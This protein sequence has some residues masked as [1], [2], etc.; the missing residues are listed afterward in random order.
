MRRS[1]GCTAT[2]CLAAAIT[3]TFHAPVTLAR[4]SSVPAA[5]GATWS[6]PTQVISPV[7]VASWIA[8]RTGTG[9][10]RLQVLVLWRG[11]PGWFL[12]PGGVSGGGSGGRYEA[13]LRYGDVQLTLGYDSARR[14]ATVH[15]KIIEMAED[16]VVFVDDVGAPTGPRVTGMTRVE[17][18]MPGSAGQIGL[19]LRQS[20]AIMSFL[21][22]EVTSPDV[23]V[24]ARLEGLCLQNIGVTR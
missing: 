13:T 15:G 9:P 2:M 5:R 21:R 18:A 8:E 24:Q 22:C 16:N 3:A 14:V 12:R 17:S 19:V 10:E 23:R 4:Q 20:P 11:A 1:A 6:A 7:V